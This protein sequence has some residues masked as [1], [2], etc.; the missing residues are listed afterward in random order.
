MA[1][2]NGGIDSHLVRD[3]M[4]KAVEYR[5]GA[6][7]APK[8]VQWLSDNGSP[9]VAGDTRR[10]AKDVGLV[11]V[12]TPVESPQ[13]SG[14]AEAFVNTLKRDYVGVNRIPDA[15]SVL[16]QR[17]GWIEHYNEHHPHST[18]KMRSPRM[19]RRERD[20]LGR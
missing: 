10:F 4:L 7:V 18:L 1:A 12:T 16:E 6:P 8:P 20:M 5:F 9:Y 17:P 2:V 19:F 11:P 14:M 3:M 13:S 15:R